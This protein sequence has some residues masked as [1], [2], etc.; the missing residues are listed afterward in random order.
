MKKFYKIKE[1]SKLY[2]IC[3]D[4]IRYYEEQGILNPRRD[5]NNYR[6]FGIQDLGNLNIIRTFR[7][8]DMPL[9]RIRT[10]IHSRTVAA[11]LE[12]LEEE[13]LVIANKIA[14]LQRKQ[15]EI[16][17]TKEEIHYALNL[18]EGCC[19]IKELPA[20][21]CFRLEEETILEGEIDFVLKRLEKEHE[22]IIHRIGSQGIG[23]YLNFEQ[24]KKGIYNHFESV[25]FF[26]TPEYCDHIL[27]PGL[28]ASNVYTGDYKKI[29][30]A[31]PRLLQFI[32]DC[33]YIM[34]GIPFELYHIDMSETNLREEYVT[35][36]QVKVKEQQIGGAE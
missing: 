35:E 24:V 1:L 31:L 26:S 22:D 23:A 30:E 32:N 7:N 19:T 21:P 28:Y 9:E 18:T 25:F 11:T 29:E 16:T 3:P 34:D 36:I 2:D 4:T 13:E 15:A 14:A 12:L 5:A 10:Y 33:G 20:R 8:L 6:L 27:P 17:A